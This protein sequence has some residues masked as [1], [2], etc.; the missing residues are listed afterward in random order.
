MHNK[1]LKAKICLWTT[2]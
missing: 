1:Q 2:Y